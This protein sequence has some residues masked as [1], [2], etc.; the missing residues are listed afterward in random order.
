MVPVDPS[1]VSFHLC[2]TPNTSDHFALL[3]SEVEKDTQNLDETCKHRLQT[4][5]RAAE[6]VFAERA[7]LL[8]ENLILFEQNNEKTCRQSA[9]QTV[10]GYA[11]VMSYEDIVEGAEETLHDG[12]ETKPHAEKEIESRGRSVTESEEKRKAEQEIQA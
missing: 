9:G 3:C 6:K 8:E 1:T 10:V 7:L 12:G 4:L 2:H 5:S 11:K